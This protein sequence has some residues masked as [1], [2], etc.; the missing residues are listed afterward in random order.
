VLRR[1]GVRA[2]QPLEIR[3]GMLPREVAWDARIDPDRENRDGREQEQVVPDGR[4][5]SRDVR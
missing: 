4:P 1:R 2:E 5:Q 3:V